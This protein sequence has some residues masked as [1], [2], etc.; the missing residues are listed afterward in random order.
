V[1]TA[2]PTVGTVVNTLTA[3][4]DRPRLFLIGVSNADT[5]D[6]AGRRFT[7]IRIRAKSNLARAPD[8]EPPGCSE[9]RVRE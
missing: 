2:N 4:A 6:I 3:N 9:A 8:I 5:A 1:N 7:M